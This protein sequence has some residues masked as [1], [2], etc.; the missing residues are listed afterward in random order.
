MCLYCFKI[1]ISKNIKIYIIYANYWIFAFLMG[2]LHFF[3]IV[4]NGHYLDVVLFCVLFVLVGKL[5]YDKIKNENAKIIR[6]A[7][8]ISIT[9]EILSLVIVVQDIRGCFSNSYSYVFIDSSFCISKKKHCRIKV[10]ESRND[11]EKENN[12][13]YIGWII[14]PALVLDRKKIYHIACYTIGI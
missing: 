9:L 6:T 11:N 10:N 5:S 3:N 1:V 2:I 4:K 12:K 7:C 14:F 8:C 13:W